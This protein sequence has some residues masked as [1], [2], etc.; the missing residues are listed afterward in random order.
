MSTLNNTKALEKELKEI[1]QL[2]QVLVVLQSAQSGMTKHQAREQAK[3]ASGQVT[4]I[5]KSLK[6]VA[7][8]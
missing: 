2:L 3:L 6:K 5:W 8:P 4:K 1:K 7:Q